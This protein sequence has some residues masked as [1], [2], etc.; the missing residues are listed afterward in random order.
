VVFIVLVAV[1]LVM[2]YLLRFRRWG[3]RLRAVGSDEESARR[4]GVPVTRTVVLAYV[5]VALFTA[6]GAVIL[7]ALLGI[8]DPAQG[9]GYTLTS[10]TA[11]VVGGTSLLG[12]R[13][14]FVGTLLGAGLIVQVLNATTF[15]GLTQTWQY[16]FQGALIVLAAVI[17]SQLLRRGTSTA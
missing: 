1:V 16:F 13:G 3:L 9:V 14:S 17:Y 8:G 4:V 11:V 15:L 7:L 5:V 10:I 2:E 6:L 12:G